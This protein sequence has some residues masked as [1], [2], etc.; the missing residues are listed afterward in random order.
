MGI[1]GELLAYFHLTLPTLRSLSHPGSSLFCNR[2]VGTVD[3]DYA[4]AYGNGDTDVSSAGGTF[5]S[6]MHNQYELDPKTA[7]A[8]GA[9]LGP[10]DDDGSF[11]AHYRAPGSNVKE[12]V[13]HVFAPPG[14]LG[15]VIDTPENGAPMVHA[16]KD[17]SV[18]FGR[19]QVGDKLVAVD[20]E[21]CRTMSA[22]K[23]SKLISRKS[24]NPSR[25]LTIVRTTTI[26]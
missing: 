21:D 2:S 9:A 20:D 15:V 25:K 17:T 5:G 10:F 19:V 12:E 24:A 23:V 18:I 6:N 26:D 7:A 16:V 3:Y 8:I 1:K 22:V 13:L 14:K 11:E 4:K